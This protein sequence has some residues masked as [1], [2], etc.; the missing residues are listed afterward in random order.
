MG[1]RYIATGLQLQ[2]TEARKLAGEAVSS[3][4]LAL[5]P[6]QAG[7]PSTNSKLVLALET[8]DLLPCPPSWA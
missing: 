2:E 7:A 1:S 8:P 5:P 6:L 4:P 3:I